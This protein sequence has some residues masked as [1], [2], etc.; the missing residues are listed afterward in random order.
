MVECTPFR[1]IITGSNPRIECEIVNKLD[2]IREIVPESAIDAA[3]RAATKSIETQ[4][5]K[6]LAKA[7]HE[8]E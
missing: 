1:E 4:I 7:R 5:G 3:M 8:L 6:G 2:Y